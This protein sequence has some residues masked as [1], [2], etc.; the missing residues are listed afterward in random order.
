MW[1]A[2]HMRHKDMLQ[3][4]RFVLDPMACPFPHVCTGC[5]HLSLTIL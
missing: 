3:R 1:E 5:Q 2:P 4:V